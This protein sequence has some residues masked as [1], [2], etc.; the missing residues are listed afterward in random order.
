MEENSFESRVKLTS[1]CK[2]CDNLERSEKAGQIVVEKSG[3]K[4]QYMFNGVK[5]LYNTYHSPWMNTIIR[6]LKG[7]H[8]PQEELCFFYVLKTLGKNANMLELGSNWS[9]YSIWFNKEI[10]HPFNICIEPIF[11]NLRNGKNNSNFND[12]RNMKFIQGSIGKDYKQNLIFENWDGDL[13]NLTQYNTEYIIKSNNNLYL[14]II[15]SDIQGSELDM[16]KGSQNVLNNIGYYI[17]ST[18]NGKHNLCIEF[19][20]NN[21]FTI[22]VE[23]TEE[24]SYSSDGLILAVNSRH[25]EKYERNI[26][27]S[28]VNYFQKNCK[29]SR[30]SS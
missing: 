14:D 27:E 11:K 9:Y 24:E 17:I 3:E 25:S 15:H 12:C 5:I 30:R 2:D 29:I 1:S 4:Y 8:E 28:L 20:K 16:L 23:H 26:S 10:E 22:L 18:H 21:S 19:L 13:I 6:N 7:H